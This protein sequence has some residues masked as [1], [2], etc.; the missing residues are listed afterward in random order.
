MLQRY[1]SS[2]DT[3]AAPSVR[4]KG[5]ERERTCDMSRSEDVVLLERPAIRRRQQEAARGSS[6]RPKS[7]KWQETEQNDISQYNKVCK[8]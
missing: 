7:L 2:V 1:H 3:K 5:R 8:P 4:L 6:A